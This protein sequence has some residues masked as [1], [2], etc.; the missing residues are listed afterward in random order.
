[1]FVAIACKVLGGWLD[2]K[3]D[4]PH[5]LAVARQDMYTI[6]GIQFE[7]LVGNVA[8]SANFGQTHLAR[9][10]NTLV[11]WLFEPAGVEV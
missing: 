11:Q 6:A 7:R 8:V 9:G 10:C 1:M 5:S 4:L 3:A 2:S